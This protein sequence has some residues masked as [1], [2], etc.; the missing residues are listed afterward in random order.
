MYPV[1]REL[2]IEL[3]KEDQRPEEDLV[4]RLTRMMYGFR[5]AS[6]GRERNWQGLLGPDK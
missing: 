1:E 4:G 6:N 3:P 2:Y 5:D